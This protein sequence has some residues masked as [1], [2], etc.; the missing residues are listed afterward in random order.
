LGLNSGLKIHSICF[1]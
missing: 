1:G